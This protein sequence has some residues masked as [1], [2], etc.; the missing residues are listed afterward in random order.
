M[1]RMYCWASLDLWVFCCHIRN[2][3]GFDDGQLI[4][5][6]GQGGLVRRVAVD[7][8]RRFRLDVVV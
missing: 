5:V 2:E 1:L 6:P 4:M 3:C 7:D 8:V